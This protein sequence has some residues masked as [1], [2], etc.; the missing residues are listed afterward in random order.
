MK[1]LHIFDLPTQEAAHRAARALG[2]QPS[3]LQGIATVKSATDGAHL[4]GMRFDAAVLHFVPDLDGKPFGLLMD[5][6]GLVTE[7]WRIGAELA[8][9]VPVG[10]ESLIAKANH[11]RFDEDDI[12]AR[13]FTAANSLPPTD[14]QR[15]SVTAVQDAIVHVAT[16]IER[17]IPNGRHKDR[18]LEDLE[19]VAMRAIRGIFAEGDR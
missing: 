15:A 8:S 7:R 16:V 17:E 6:V 13:F 11:M 4:R 12:R 14:A 19:A 10:M 18:A 3:K 1:T 2:I 9:I 5:Q